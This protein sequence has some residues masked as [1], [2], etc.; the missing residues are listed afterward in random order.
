MEQLRVIGTEGESLILATESGERFELVVDDVVRHEIR[1]AGQQ[2]PPVASRPGPKEIQSR[3]R[4][5]LSSHEVADLLEI[6]LANVERFETPVL[7]ERE[8]VVN[9]ALATKVLLGGDFDPENPLTFGEAIRAKLEE[10]LASDEHWSSW[11]EET[12]WIVKLAF[13]REDVE[14]D[15]R[16]SFDPRHGALSPRNSDA[17]QLS[18]QGSLPEG[19]IP[20]LRAVDASSDSDEELTD[21]SSVTEGHPSTHLVEEAPETVADD[22][23]SHDTADLLEALRRRRGQRESAPLFE[24]EDDSDMPEVEPSP[25][26]TLFDELEPEYIDPV[27]EEDR[28]EA[29]PEE[30]PTPE[31]APAP[32]PQADEAS[33]SDDSA[34]RRKRRTSMPSWDDIVFGA[35]TDD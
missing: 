29:Q 20:R 10:A 8:H 11:K 9:Q 32:A 15:A 30:L 6:P 13:T 35:R 18:R 1:K 17:I 28:V 3:L 24:A 7:A 31:P 25:L 5:G 12:G 22:S 14:H 4:S 2:R 19:L 21:A 33:S 26:V 16:W 34:A 27:V 23:S